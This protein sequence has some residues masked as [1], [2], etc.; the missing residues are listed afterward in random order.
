MQVFSQIAI[1]YRLLRL[2]RYFGWGNVN[3]RNRNWYSWSLYP[4]LQC[5]LL[6]LGCRSAERA[7]NL[8]TNID[9]NL[10]LYGCPGSA[11][12]CVHS[13]TVSARYG[14]IPNFSTRQRSSY[15]CEYFFCQL[16]KRHRAKL[17]ARQG[18]INVVFPVPC[19][20]RKTAS[21]SSSLL[22]RQTAGQLRIVNGPKHFAVHFD[23]V[24]TAERDVLDN[25]KC[26]CFH[27]RAA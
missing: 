23:I 27:G 8:I 3:Y 10:R 14:A 2:F 24:L 25:R 15:F 12:L 18:S 16:Q 7:V 1:Y 21:R 6:R 19:R 5:E 13:M 4:N 9:K 11:S 20:S 22:I 26:P 17:S